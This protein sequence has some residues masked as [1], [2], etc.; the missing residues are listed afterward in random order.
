MLKNISPIPVY[1]TINE[2]RKSSLSLL[3]VENCRIDPRNQNV[4]VSMK[5]YSTNKYKKCQVEQV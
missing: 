2:A 3:R 1:V 4:M 5:T